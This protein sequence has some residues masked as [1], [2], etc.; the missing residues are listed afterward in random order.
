MLPDVAELQLLFA[1]LNYEYFGGEI[2]AHRIAYNRR[3][4]NLAGR[5]TYR[6]PLIELSPRHF[7][8]RPEALRETLLHEMIHAW[9]HARKR[10]AGH[11]RA[12]KEKMRELGMR[13]IY[14]DLATQDDR[15]PAR[16]LLRCE[17]CG[18]E[19]PRVRR[20][21]APVSCG[22]CNPRRFDPRDLLRLVPV[23]SLPH[24]PDL[25]RAA[26]RGLR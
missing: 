3:F 13:S 20:P 23:E 15:S 9:L 12:F 6:P 24:P 1:R 25:R 21:R 22:R 11:T 14:H 16:F 10:P 26:Q 8:R 5:I 18:L 2:P 19:L 4:R 17:R 7:E